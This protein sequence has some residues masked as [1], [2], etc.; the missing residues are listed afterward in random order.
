MVRRLAGL[1]CLAALLASGLAAAN[2]GAAG[3]FADASPDDGSVHVG[4]AD[5]AV[6]AHVRASD[7]LLRLEVVG[8]LGAPVDLVDCEGA[9]CYVSL[10]YRVGVVDVS[11]VTR[12]R[13]L[14]ETDVLPSEP[15]RLVGAGDR[16]YVLL[17]GQVAVVDATDP[18]SP[19]VAGVTDDLPAYPT[20]RPLDV[21]ASGSYAYVSGEG[22]WDDADRLLGGWLHVIDATDPSR[23]HTVGVVRLP[24]HGLR[25]DLEGDRAYVATGKDGVSIVDVAV[26]D[27]AREIGAVTS[28]LGTTVSV[29]GN[30]LFTAGTKGF[31]VFDV[32]DPSAP[33]VLGQWDGGVVDDIRAAGDRAYLLRAAQ[34]YPNEF[35][36]QVVDVTDPAAI[37][38][39]G[40]YR[41]DSAVR[42]DVRE[43][44]VFLA[45]GSAGLCV[46]DAKRV[47][48]ARLFGAAHFSVSPRGVHV[49]GAYAYLAADTEGLRIV[50][51][52]DWAAPREVGA[53]DTPGSAAAVVV[54]GDYAYVADAGGGLRIVDVR[55]PAA[56]REVGAWTEA[57]A[58]GVAVEGTFAYVIGWR[59]AQEGSE[60]SIIDASDPG[61]PRRVGRMPTASDSRSRVQVA[62]G[63]VFVF[64]GR[65]GIAVVDVSDPSAPHD[66][67][68]LS[69][70]SPTD[71]AVAAGHIF[72]AEPTIGLAIIDV[73]ALPARR[74]VGTLRFM[75]RTDHVRVVGDVAYVTGRFSSDRGRWVRTIDVSDPSH[76]RETGL[77][78]L[79]GHPAPAG[80]PY[81]PSG[82]LTGLAVADGHAYVTTDYYRSDDTTLGHLL[83][84][85]MRAAAP[86][87]EIGALSVMG[88]DPIAVV[89][90][91][92]YVAG[93]VRLRVVDVG[94]PSAPRE[95]GSVPIPG[96]SVDVR[97]VGDH[98][99]LAAGDTGLRIVNVA[100]PTHPRAVGALDTPGTARGVDVGAGFAFVAAGSDGLW[101]IDVRDPSAPRMVASVA[102]DYAADVVVIG[103]HAFVV[104]DRFRSVDVSDPAAPRVVGTA[105]GY[106][107][108]LGLNQARLA[109]Q[110]SRVYIVDA[111]PTDG[112]RLIVVDCSEPTTPRLVHLQLRRNGAMDVAI[113]G[114][115]TY[116]IDAHATLH[117]VDVAAGVDSFEWDAIELAPSGARYGFAPAYVGVAG[118]YA[119]VSTAPSGLTIVGTVEHAV[120]ARLF[121]PFAVCAAGG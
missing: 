41:S 28:A 88:A 37:V 8:H 71:F 95:V 80:T 63:Y 98:V 91:H 70:T 23:P 114:E 75:G 74:T 93:D 56:P 105:S 12:P 1:L 54:A 83:A 48:P 51:V 104:G 21:T 118:D 97:A 45:A 69:V 11:D 3:R 16:A 85:D 14:G 112:G 108:L 89:D 22:P 72:V 68:D 52:H 78:E 96:G 17:R 10:R 2:V 43:G 26:P 35:G 42:M 113:A 66:V 90:S 30:R 73:T 84:I 38:A 100:D 33:R 55:D 103:Q 7:V 61:A 101:V 121:L 62:G 67:T 50:D 111:D 102:M 81:T 92:A 29:D 57:P 65:N 4:T 117:V 106:A 47:R 116:V 13:L 18:A 34:G 46:V 44:T 77:I 53:V 25:V 36:V 94:D 120:A 27:A 31:Q 110:G 19:R 79:P 119:Y 76:A 82:D 86:A 6:A 115:R 40:S 9:R 20:G 60:L 109:V 24:N 59:G 5:A 39:I 99:Y 15:D 107:T 64:H 58:H 32:R 49:D 87:A